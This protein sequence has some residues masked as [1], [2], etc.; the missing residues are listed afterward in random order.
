MSKK[1][2]LFVLMAS[3]AIPFAIANAGR[4][5]DAASL[6]RKSD[7]SAEYFTN[8]YG[9][10]LLPTVGKG[11]LGVGAAHGSGHVYSNG[12]LIGHVSMN[13]LSV[14]I[15]AGGEA[16]SE[17][18]FFKDK[19]A[20]DDFTSGHFEFSADAGA[21]VIT[22][23]ADASIGTTGAN[24]G[25]SVEKHDAATAGEYKHGMAVFTIA[26]GG[27]MYNVSIAGQKFSFTPN[28]HS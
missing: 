27:L 7:K 4:D 28:T 17:I 1:V 15:Q 24:G 22:A 25:A 16:Y 11:G 9:Y 12:H 13:Q 20:L 26:K 6:F 3:V 19:S 14:G 5:S 10:A 18:I 2:G 8:S 23:G 21:V